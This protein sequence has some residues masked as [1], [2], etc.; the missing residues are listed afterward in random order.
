[1]ALTEQMI[2]FAKEGAGGGGKRRGRGGNPVRLPP[3]G[4]RRRLKFDREHRLPFAP[5]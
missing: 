5:G 2:M 1:M 3:V 4:R